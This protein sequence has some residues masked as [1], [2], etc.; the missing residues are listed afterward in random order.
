MHERKQ[1]MFE[2]SDAF[3]ALPGGLGTTEE[4][5]EQLTWTQLGQSN[6]PIVLADIDGFWQ[7]LL[8]LFRHME[9]EAFIREGLEL[10]LT[11]V[12]RPEDILPTALKLAAKSEA[13]AEEAT[14]TAKF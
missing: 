2:K 6:K 7:P 3:V 4:L 1:L 13:G 14:V 5:V 8:T 11:S 12:T 9:A 10:R